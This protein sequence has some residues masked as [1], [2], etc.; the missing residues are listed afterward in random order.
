[1][2]DA[3]FFDKDAIITLLGSMSISYI[4][5]ILLILGSK[6]NYTFEEICLNL[7][8][9]KIKKKD[10]GLIPYETSSSML[11]HQVVKL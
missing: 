5:G 10:I 1:V 11:F 3:K 9:G 6:F 2:C 7:L 4:E 8:K